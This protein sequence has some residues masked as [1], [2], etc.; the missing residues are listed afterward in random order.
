MRRV[1]TWMTV[2]FGLVGVA[3]GGAGTANIDGGNGPPSRCA[4]TTDEVCCDEAN[5]EGACTPQCVK[6]SSCPSAVCRILPDGGPD[7]GAYGAPCLGNSGFCQMN[8]GA[9]TG[10]SAGQAS[11]GAGLFCCEGEWVP[12]PHD[13]GTEAATSGCTTAVDCAHGEICVVA[14]APCSAPPCGP[15][16]TGSCQPN[17]CGADPLA[18]CGAPLVECPADGAASSCATMACS[19]LGSCTGVDSTEGVVHC[20][21]GG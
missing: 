20:Q 11:C 8:G 9:C 7:G 12:P 21:G 17:P 18:C 5:A 2:G 3:C 16:C 10:V 6:G 1:R 14:C 4:C 19:G 15:A 13:G